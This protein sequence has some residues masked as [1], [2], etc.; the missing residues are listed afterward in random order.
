VSPACCLAS[1]E[2]GGGGIPVVTRLG[3][4]SGWLG[5]VAACQMVQGQFGRSMQCANMPQS[6]CTT[7][8]QVAHMEM[9]IDGWCNGR[10][11]VGALS[12]SSGLQ[13]EKQQA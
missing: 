10:A 6:L 13:P 7:H 5:G 12:V 4:W 8:V 3:G 2:Q 1:G 11:V 9:A